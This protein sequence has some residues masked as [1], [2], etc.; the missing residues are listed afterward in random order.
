MK[1]FKLL[2]PAHTQNQH[3]VLIG[4]ARG[5]VYVSIEHF[6]DIN[7][8]GADILYLFKAKITADYNN[9]TAHIAFK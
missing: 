4:G 6:S 1:S 3:H 9:G 7:L 2:K 8:L 5:I